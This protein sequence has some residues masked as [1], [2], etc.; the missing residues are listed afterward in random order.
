MKIGTGN[1]VLGLYERTVDLT[2]RVIKASQ[3]Q[4]FVHVYLLEI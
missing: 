3:M 4:Y 2:W 1:D